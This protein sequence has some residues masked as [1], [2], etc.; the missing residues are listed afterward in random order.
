MI[1]SAQRAAKARPRGDPPAWQVTGCPWGERGADSGPRD[2]KYVPSWNTGRTFS[3]SA[4]I[5]RSL[6]MIIASASQESHSFST[7]WM[8]SSAIS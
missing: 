8:Y 3:G 5:S 1:V 6:S 4:K 7:T 2:R